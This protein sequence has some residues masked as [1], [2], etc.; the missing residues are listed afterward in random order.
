M[1]EGL[2]PVIDVFLNL[3]SGMI[4]KFVEMILSLTIPSESSMISIKYHTS[5]DSATDST[6]LPDSAPNS[7]LDSAPDSS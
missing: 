2:N 3:V 6:Q 4:L 5:L 7:A 1:G